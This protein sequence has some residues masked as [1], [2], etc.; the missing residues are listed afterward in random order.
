MH[1]THAKQSSR[2]FAVMLKKESVNCERWQTGD[3]SIKKNYTLKFTSYIREVLHCTGWTNK[4][5]H[6]ECLRNHESKRQIARFHQQK[7]DTKQFLFSKFFSYSHGAGNIRGGKSYWPTLYT[8]HTDAIRKTYLVLNFTRRKI[9]ARNSLL[10]TT[11]PKQQQKE[12]AS[13]RIN[14]GENR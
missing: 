5:H 4:N 11:V 3:G 14:S 13:S 2:T 12:H 7:N 6:L 9:S 8:S 10:T 1:T